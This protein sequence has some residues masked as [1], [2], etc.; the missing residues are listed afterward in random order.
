[1]NCIISSLPSSPICESATISISDVWDKEDENLTICN[2]CKKMVKNK[3]NDTNTE[4][5]IKR[6]NNSTFQSNQKN[7][8]TLRC[9]IPPSPTL[10]DTEPLQ[11]S[12]VSHNSLH[13]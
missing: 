13:L 12:P 8:S 11:F 6:E 9:I 3:V 1:M 2:G 5:A 7:K 10:D 4:S